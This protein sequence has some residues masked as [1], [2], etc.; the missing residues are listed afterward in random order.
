MK[1]NRPPL[2]LRLES[3]L[4]SVHQWLQEFS[5][6]ET[7][8]EILTQAMGQS[9]SR[10][11]AQLLQQ[12]WRE[13]NFSTLPQVEIRTQAELQTAKAAYAIDTNIIYLSEQFLAH[14]ADTNLT[15]TL[16]EEVGH[17]VDAKINATDT[18]GDEGAIFSKLIRGQTIE[19]EQLQALRQEDDTA[20][21]IIDGQIFSVE[22]ATV[23]DSGGFEGS[24]QTLK[25]GTNGGGKAIVSYEHYTIPDQIQLR[26]EG[27]NILDTG[28]VP[29]NK[30]IEVD[31]PQGNSDE[32]EVILA[33]NDEDT[34]WNYKVSNE[35]KAYLVFRETDSGIPGWDHVGLYFNGKVYEA[36]P[37]Y[38]AGDYQD[39]RQNKPVPISKI[40]GVQA[41]HTLG[42]FFYN[43]K[44]PGQPFKGR[45]KEIPNSLAKKM[46]E[47]IEGKLGTA[48]YT[49]ENGW[50]QGFLLGN[51]KG[52]DQFTCVGL[53]EWAA[54][55][56]GLNG[57][58]GFIPTLFERF[59][60]PGNTTI[61][62]LFGGTGFLLPDHLLIYADRGTSN[63]LQGAFDPVDFILTDPLGRRLGHT[64]ATG[65]LNEIPGALY[66]GDGELEQFAIFEP[67]PG[68]YKV[69]LFGL[70]E[71]A[72]A[73][74]DGSSIQEQSFEGFLGAGETRTLVAT[75][76][77]TSRSSGIA[78][79]AITRTD[80]A[81]SVNLGQPYTYTL[82]VTNQGRD[83]ATGVVLEETLPS[84]VTFVSGQIN[85]AGATQAVR[86]SNGVVT[87]N[88]DTLNQ[89]GVATVDLTVNPIAAGDLVSRTT[90]VSN[91]ADSDITNNV[92][93]STKTISSITPA[94]ADLELSQTISNFIPTVNSEI[95]LTL[96][97]TNKGL[98]TASGVQVSDLLPSGLSFVSA[99]TVQGSYDSATGV[100]DVGNL[101][102][103]L[104]RTLTVTAR[105][106]GT[107]AITNVAEVSAVRE[108]DP[109]SSPANNVASED[110]QTSVTL[111]GIPTLDAFGKAP[112]PI[113]FSKGKAGVN[114]RGTN[115]NDRLSG[116]RNRDI[117]RGLSGNDR[118]NGKNHNDRLSGGAGKDTLL[119]GRQRDLLVGNAGDDLLKGEGGA[120]ILV[121]GGGKDTLIGGS[122]SDLFVLDQRANSQDR[123]VGFNSSEDLLDLRG[124]L[125]QAQ[126]SG[127]ARP[128]Q[129][130]EYIELVQVGSN[131]EIR[132]DADG[133]GEGTSFTTLVTLSN[134]PSNAVTTR[135]FVIA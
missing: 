104:S 40:N 1:I 30:T 113:D 57:G 33:T 31:I 77:R 5:L 55:K 71:N 132:L 108:L 100:W 75:V 135:N 126:F 107:G 83:T 119:G 103:G 97:L 36:H 3:A 45:L 56:A 66:S 37:G 8:F 18:P 67:L 54:E 65:T 115:R 13:G 128:A 4:I 114:L 52:E 48:S 93:T 86:V 80:I 131:T 118:L 20:T 74:I 68:E 123:I 61:G 116:T 87:A 95:D 117:L 129:F 43:P 44:N 21:L 106:T 49:F 62:N 89:G 72:I 73:S 76:P 63:W 46:A 127:S 92:I 2:N 98:G 14:G 99:R 50:L 125:S 26:Y 53:I 124:I 9:F 110:D 41:I 82:A 11:Q 28:F 19:A 105:V 94:S 101:R 111:L 112:S 32:L 102:N 23:S 6:S 96:A 42:S 91:Q 109:D 84:G 69:E 7:F 22:Q 58:A 130:V 25:L 64:A 38:D 88:I 60:I 121:G 79:V 39:T 12:Q 90:V 134:T 120:D 70:D 85:R 47:A 35:D 34:L 16:L 133:K 59:L 81:N 29:G 51:Q 122:S 10:E 17:F 24:R 78:D 15:T 27:K